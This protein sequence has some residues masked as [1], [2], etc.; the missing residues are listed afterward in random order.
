[1]ENCPDLRHKVLD[2][3]DEI[4]RGNSRHSAFDPIFEEPPC[5]YKD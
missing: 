5:D 2:K 3:Y 1:M 4:P